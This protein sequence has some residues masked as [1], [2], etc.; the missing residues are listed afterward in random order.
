VAGTRPSASRSATVAARKRWQWKAMVQGAAFRT[1]GHQ[2]WSLSVCGGDSSSVKKLVVEVCSRCPVPFRSRCVTVCL[3]GEPRER[4][5]AVP[6]FGDDSN[7]SY[8]WFV[9]LGW[10]LIWMDGVDWNQNLITTF[11]IHG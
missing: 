9:F 1:G 10:G 6:C 5:G 7:P 8:V 3:V 2:G 11:A 4:S